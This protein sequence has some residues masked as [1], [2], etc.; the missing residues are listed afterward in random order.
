MKLISATNDFIRTL[1]AVP[2]IVGQLCYIA[3][4]RNEDGGY[5]HWGL[6]KTH[7]PEQATDSIITAHKI[8]FREVLRAPMGRLCSE[9]ASKENEGVRQ[10]LLQHL[11][12]A[13]A[14]ALP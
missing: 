4:L 5:D 1:N 6:I 10:E 2:G 8:I 7:G 9:I 12:T 11:G 13:C 14:R 3:R